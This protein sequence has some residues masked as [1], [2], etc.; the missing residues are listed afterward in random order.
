LLSFCDQL[1]NILRK[2]FAAKTLR[3]NDFGGI[4]C[5]RRGRGQSLAKV[6]ANPVTQDSQM[7][8]FTQSRSSILARLEQAGLHPFNATAVP[9]QVS[10][11]PRRRITPTAATLPT[12][13]TT[14]LARQ[15]PKLRVG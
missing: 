6:D 9:A 2:G 11:S 14:V 4:W 13:R 7:A 5:G 12:D 8:P 10:D 1:G 15:T 3:H